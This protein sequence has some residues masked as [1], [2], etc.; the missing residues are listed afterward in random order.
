MDMGRW[1][2]GG[3]AG[4]GRAVEGSGGRRDIGTVGWEWE[5]H[6]KMA[7]GALEEQGIHCI[8]KRK[9]LKTDSFD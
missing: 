2:H 4:T 3:L 8:P 6:T 9:F 1:S 5:L 7:R